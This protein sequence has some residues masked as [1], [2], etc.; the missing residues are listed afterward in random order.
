MIDRYWRHG[1]VGQGY[2]AI[3]MRDVS[4][5]SNSPSLF[6]CSYIANSYSCDHDE[7]VGVQCYGKSCL[8]AAIY[9]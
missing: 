2:G 6:S 5:S 4:C 1:E 7:D 8:L 9:N 3:N